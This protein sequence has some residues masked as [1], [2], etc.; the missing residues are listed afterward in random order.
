MDRTQH[1]IHTEQLIATLVYICNRMKEPFIWFF[2]CA[3]IP[4]S[5]ILPEGVMLYIHSLNH[6]RISCLLHCHDY[7]VRYAGTGVL[8]IV[9]LAWILNLGK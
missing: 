1:K 6:T 7:N 3:C 2:I 5:I 4:F 9:K 8:K